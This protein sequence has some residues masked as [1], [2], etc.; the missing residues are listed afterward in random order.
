VNDDQIVFICRN[1]QEWPMEYLMC[2]DSSQLDA[3]KAAYDAIP[4]D[5]TR[6]WP[7]RGGYATHGEHI[8]HCP[9]MKIVFLSEHVDESPAPPRPI[10]SMSVE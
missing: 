1:M 4:E 8:E 6:P 10:D 7:R 2:W 5:E 9:R 3:L